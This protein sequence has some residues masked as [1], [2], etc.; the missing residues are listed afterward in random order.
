MKGRL[1]SFGITLFASTLIE[2]S[3]EI[4]VILPVAEGDIGRPGFVYIGSGN[5]AAEHGSIKLRPFGE[6]RQI[7]YEIRFNVSKQAICSNSKTPVVTLWAG[8]ATV[9]AAV[10]ANTS[11]YHGY[12]NPD[13]A[14]E[15]TRLYHATR[16]LERRRSYT[17]VVDIRCLANIVAT[18]ETAP[19]SAQRTAPVPAATRAWPL[20]VGDNLQQKIEHWAKEEGWFLVWRAQDAD[21][22]VQGPMRVEAKNFEGAIQYLFKALP[23][24]IGLKYE[25]RANQAPPYLIVYKDV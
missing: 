24:G 10:D 17:K 12:L 6:Y 2:A 8:Y 18:P 5:E 20:E 13:I 9:P 3:A 25:T 23:P 4:P 21:F 11:E 22:I 19:D 7:P 14:T 16:Q 15:K 1:I